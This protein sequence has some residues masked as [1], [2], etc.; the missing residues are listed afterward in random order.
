MKFATPTAHGNTP[1]SP[2][3]TA[4]TITRKQRNGSTRLWGCHGSK[5]SSLPIAQHKPDA[6]AMAATT[7]RGPAC[8]H[9]TIAMPLIETT[10]ISAT[11]TAR[12]PS[13]ASLTGSAK[14]SNRSGPGLLI[15]IPSDSEADVHVPS[16][17]WCSVNTSRARIKKYAL[18]LRA[19]QSPA[20]VRTVA[21]TIGT[22]ASTTHATANGPEPPDRPWARTVEV[23][24]ALACAAAPSPGASR[25]RGSIPT[26]TPM[27]QPAVA[28]DGAESR[29]PLQRLGENSHCE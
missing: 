19:T 16:R 8:R 28:H 21:T 14:T 7:P 12:P 20:T 15:G 24:A 22:I 27:A 26:F 25:S 6:A 10:L 9:A 11:P 29:A 1:M 2:P 17:G 3:A 5:S 13:P 4:Q 18:S 23:V